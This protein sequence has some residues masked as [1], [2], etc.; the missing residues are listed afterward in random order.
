MPRKKLPPLEVGQAS[1]AADFDYFEYSGAA[2]TGSTAILRLR[3]K[4]GTTIDPPATEEA[5]K[6]LGSRPVGS[7]GIQLHPLFPPEEQV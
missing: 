3:L 1:V 5:L 7:C 6:H 2:L 4:N